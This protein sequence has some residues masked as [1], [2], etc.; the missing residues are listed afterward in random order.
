[1][2]DALSTLVIEGEYGDLCHE[3][4]GVADAIDDKL[5]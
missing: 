1:M 3:I 4:R 2:V 5:Q